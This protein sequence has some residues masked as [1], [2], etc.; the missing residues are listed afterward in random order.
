LYIDNLKQV[1]TK[2]ISLKLPWLIS[3]SVKKHQNFVTVK[4]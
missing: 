3:L 4:S 1:R 2:L